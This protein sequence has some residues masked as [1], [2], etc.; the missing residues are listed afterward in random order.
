LKLLIFLKSKKAKNVICTFLPFYHQ[1]KFLLNNKRFKFA[2]LGAL[3]IHYF[4]IN[5]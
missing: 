5:K 2:L 4:C 1:I 3:K